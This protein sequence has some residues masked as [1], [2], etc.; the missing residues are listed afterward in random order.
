MCEWDFD[1][2][3][4][5]PCILLLGWFVYVDRENVN[6]TDGREQSLQIPDWHFFQPLSYYYILFVEEITCCWIVCVRKELQ[7]RRISRKRVK[8]AFIEVKIYTLLVDMS[9]I[10]WCLMIGILF[11]LLKIHCLKTTYKLNSL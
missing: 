6:I 5:L 10:H 8:N 11:R 7:Y 1:Q 4:C 3:M 2:L 9:K